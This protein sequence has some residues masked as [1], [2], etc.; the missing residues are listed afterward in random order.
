MKLFNKSSIYISVS[1]LAVVSV[2]A[3]IFYFVIVN[4]MYD[5]LDDT[6]EDQADLIINKAHNDSSLLQ[7]NGFGL[8]NFSITDTINVKGRKKTYVTTSIFLPYENEVKEVRMLTQIFD[9]NGKFYALKIVTSIVDTEDVVDM[10]VQSIFW[11][12]IVTIFVIVLLNAVVLKNL[13]RPFYNTINSLKTYQLD[14][15]KLPDFNK[16]DIQEFKELNSALKSLFDKNLEI[17]NSQKQFIENASHEL[18]TPLAIAI[19]KLEL[20]TDSGNLS[21]NQLEQVGNSLEH[22]TRITRLNKSLLLLSKIENRQFNQHTAIDISLLTRDIIADFEQQLLFKE[23]QINIISDPSVQNLHEDLARILIINLIKNAIVH[24][25]QG[26]E[27][28]ITINEHIFSISNSGTA[29][30][31]STKIFSRF[32]KDIASRSSTGLGLA[33]IKAIVDLY[34]FSVTYR[35]KNAHIFEIKF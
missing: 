27:I 13:W 5:N 18:Q 33:I 16:S 15:S 24:N 19:N 8:E 17:F 31:D 32:Y 11:L 26:G 6:L 12:F 25:L 14:N 23:I 9:I 7:I 35:F 2:W 3:F 21:D 28:F 10:I 34:G 4:E 30:L 22:L 29:P 1:F 20:L